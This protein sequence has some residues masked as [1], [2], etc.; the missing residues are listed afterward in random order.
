MFEHKGYEQV[1]QRTLDALDLWAEMA[2]PPGGFLKAVLQN[3]L[4]SAVG[5]AD[6]ENLR[7]LP[8]IVEYC[9]NELPAT[10]WGSPENYQKHEEGKLDGRTKRVR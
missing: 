8:R 5:R 9:Y 7:A 10:C 2:I 1:P 3:D 4:F 6:V